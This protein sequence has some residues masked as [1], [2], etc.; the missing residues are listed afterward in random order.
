LC[1]LNRLYSFAPWWRP[2]FISALAPDDR[3]HLNGIGTVNGQVRYV[4]ALGETDGPGSW[5]ENKKNSG[6]L[7]EVPSGNIL[8]RGLSMPHS[9]RW[10]QGK[11]WLLESGTGTIGTVDLAAGRYEAITEVPGFTRGLDFY[12]D[13]AFVGLSQVRESAVF[14]GIP[15]TDRLAERTCGVWVVDI[16][17][18]KVVAFLR[19]EAAV[20]EI[21]A[22]QVLPQM[23][24]PD[25]INDHSRVLSDSFVLS[26]AALS[27]LPESIRG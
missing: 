10:H 25:L 6:I 27:Q 2:P 13:L 21:F 7:M 22:V 4:T 9:P 15:L 19:F 12:G 23:R 11:L 5:R 26:D 3:C 20:Q 8:V 18:G 1:T 24:F 17:R 14:S 16:A